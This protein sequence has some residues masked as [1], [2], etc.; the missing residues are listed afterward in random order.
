MKKVILCI[1]MLLAV[2][3]GNYAQSPFE[4]DPKGVT[5]SPGGGSSGGGS[6]GNSCTDVDLLSSFFIAPNYR[7]WVYV[8]ATL[9]S[10]GTVLLIPSAVSNLCEP[11]QN[12]FNFAST[13]GSACGGNYCANIQFGYNLTCPTFFGLDVEYSLGDYF[14]T[15]C[16][17]FNSGTCPC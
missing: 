4:F 14:G 17:S 13:T 10:D 8:E 7:L 6:S 11:A 2:N 15:S 5:I 1:L 12:I 16:F 9:L 3:I